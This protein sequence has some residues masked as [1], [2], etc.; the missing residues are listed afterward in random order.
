MADEAAEGAPEEGQ[1]PGDEGAD[2]LDGVA[3]VIDLLRKKDVLS[4]EEAAEFLEWYGT[5]REEEKKAEEAKEAQ[6]IEKALSDYTPPPP[7]P[8]PIKPKYPA[9]LEWASRFR[10][11]GD[12]RLRYQG[13]FYQDG[14]ADLLDPADP[15]SLLNTT[16]D[17]H[18]FRY[19]LRLKASAKVNDQM[20]AVIRLATGN[21]DNP[22]STND[23]LGDTLN[24]DTIVFDQAY[25]QWKPIRVFSMYGG[26]FPNIFYK[27]DLVWDSDV[28]L[29][30]F[31]LKTTPRISRRVRAF[32]VGAAISIQEEE[33]S[34]DD[35]WLF[36]GQGGVEFQPWRYLLGKVG[37]SYY[38]Y[39]RIQGEA[40]D[41]AQP[42]A[43]DFTAPQF[44]QKG[45]TLFDID[46]DPGELLLALASDY[47]ILNVTSELDFSVFTPYHITI[48]FD[49]ARNL[50]FDRDEVAARTGL[51]DVVEATDGYQIGLKIGKP[52]IRFLGDWRLS[53]FYKRLE[54]DAVL[55]AFT[56][57]DF[58]GGGTNAV[59]WIVKGEVGLYDNVWLVTRWLTT[60]EID[61]PPLAIDTLQ[62]DLNA[63]Y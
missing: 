34:S 58:H 26:R 59:G 46:P 56:D 63:R 17:R 7:P 51:T 54:S 15:D 20:Q 38:S 60:D 41:P 61:G 23:T 29:E 25:L 55:D 13:D 2:K 33:F 57:S 9:A 11:G 18:R 24:K 14:N 5:K 12:I 19:R 32:I 22:V 28:N 49:W 35:K 1:A 10:F 53:A 44:Q 47:D 3:G 62:V 39:S 6:K 40:N 31:A 16:Q 21:E 45:N 43:N 8:P 48:V 30:G 50:G 42:G 36:A 4:D 52:K 27:T 37:V